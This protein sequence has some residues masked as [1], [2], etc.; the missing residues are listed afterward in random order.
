MSYTSQSQLAQD[1]AF[2]G[3]VTSV[4]VEQANIFKDDGR[5][6]FVSLA[7]AVLRGSHEH[8]HAFVRLISVGPGIGDKADNGDGTID[9]TQVTDGDL[10]SLTQNNWP[11]IAELYYNEDGTVQPPS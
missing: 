9:Q 7:N 2:Q 5:P 8:T 11:V 6:G 1:M 4:A 10:L 3:R